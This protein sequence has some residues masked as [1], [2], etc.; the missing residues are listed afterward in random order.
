[1]GVNTAIARK[2]RVIPQLRCRLDRLRHHDTAESGWACGWPSIRWD[3]A[4]ARPRAEAGTVFPNP[5][6]DR[7][8]EVL[9]K[10]LKH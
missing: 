8:R 2:V 10:I 9:S 5:R 3:R 7:A 1:M 4:L 6:G